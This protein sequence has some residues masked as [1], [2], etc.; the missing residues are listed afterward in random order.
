MITREQRLAQQREYNKKF[1]AANREREKNR[2]S[3][4]RS[5]NKDKHDAATKAWRA[6]NPDRVKNA[7]REWNRANPEKNRAYR[8]KRKPVALIKAREYK[9]KHKERLKIQRRIWLRANPEGNRANA[10]AWAK[11]NPDKVNARCMA[12]YTAKMKAMPPWADREKIRAFYTEAVRL[13][14]ETGIPHEVDHIYPLKSKW[15]CGLHVPA[16]LQILTESENCS[17][18]NRRWPNMPADL[19]I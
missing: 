2:A 19:R 13:T 6:E 7:K 15:L 14:R 5:Q 1:Y 4:W 17:K 18:G 16:N 10:K 3:T 12:R 9:S 8:E 11:K